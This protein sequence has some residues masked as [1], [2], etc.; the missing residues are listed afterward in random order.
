MWIQGKKAMWQ[1]RLICFYEIS[2]KQP[3]DRKHLG[4]QGATRNLEETDRKFP[5][6]ACGGLKENVP[7]SLLGHS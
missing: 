3:Q 4:L 6:N 7:H 1:Q 2:I 5:K